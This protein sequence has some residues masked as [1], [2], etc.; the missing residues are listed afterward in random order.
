[1][2][3]ILFKKAQFRDAKA[4]ALV[5]RHAFDD[6]VNYGAPGPGG[7]PGYKSDRWQSKMMRLGT[8][9]K[10]LRDERIIGG[11]IVFLKGAGHYELGR[12]FLE[13]EFQNQGIGKLAFDFLWQ[14]FPFALKWTLGTP[15]WN[16]R[17]QHFYKKMGFVVVGK[18]G[19]D[20]VL[21]EKQM[22]PAIPG[23]FLTSPPSS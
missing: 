20:G 12:I 9:Y 19:P 18:D 17:N 6:D 5:S 22:T 3:E 7:P 8:Y 14:E 15:A 16:L 4:L 23:T 11:I 10:I 1:M 2:A 13:P 21:F